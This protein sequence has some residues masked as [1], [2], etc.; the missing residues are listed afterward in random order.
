MMYQSAV[1]G[2]L[3]SVQYFDGTPSVTVYSAGSRSW[4]THNPGLLATSLFTY[5]QGCI[6]SALQVAAFPD[7]ATGRRAL[8]TLLSSQDYVPL[9]VLQTL[10]Q[11]IPHYQPPAREY[12]K[13]TREPLPWI[14]KRTDSDLEL[15]MGGVS[16]TERQRLADFIER[17]IGYIPGVIT[18]ELLKDGSL[19]KASQSVSGAGQ[20]ISIN[21]RTAVHAGSAGLLTTMDV[22]N[23]PSG[24][25][26]PPRLYGNVARSG[27]SART[28][29]SVFIN[30]N[31]ACHRES[32][33]SVSSG[34]EPGRCGGIRSGT[35]KQKAEFISASSNVLIEGKPA[36]RQFDLMVSN[37]RNT[38]PAPL[39]QPGAGKPPVLSREGAKGLDESTVPDRLD[40]TSPHVE[41]H[42]L[43]G[44]FVDKTD[45]GSSDN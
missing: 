37:N 2:P 12:D 9:T 42:F 43:K 24:D 41:A 26:C 21:R 34:D 6:G 22:C 39:M 45:D 23:T 8:V 30:G 15:P 16:G 4:R 38:P 7:I 17:E 33:F 35:I 32:M 11:F 18:K 44:R 31:P 36:V 29:T 20:N 1:G 10:K 13:I 3:D 25:S 14:E 5:D 28:A 27:D 19:K 40:V